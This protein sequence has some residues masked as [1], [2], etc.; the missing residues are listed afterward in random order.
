MKLRRLGA[1]GIIALFAAAA[2]TPGATPGTS[3]GT[4]PG[5][6][7]G[8]TPGTTPDTTPGTTPGALGEIVIGAGEPILIGTALAITGD[9]ATLGLD[10]Q[11]GAEI[12]GD[13][14]NEAGGLLGHDIAWA[15]EDAGCA[16]A[17]TGQ[18][19][20]QSLV[21]NDN[22]VAVIGT[23]CSRTAVPAAPVLAQ[24]G[25]ILIS[26]ANTSPTLTDPTHAEFA[27]DFYLRSAHNDL[28][29]G[30]AVA[31]YACE[32]D[33]T[34]AA[35]VHDGSTYSDNLRQAFERAFE[36]QCA[37]EIVSQ[38]ATT[39]DEVNFAGILGPIADAAP[40][41]IFLP[42]FHPAGTSII[43][44]ARDIT[45]LNDTQLVGTDGMLGS[46]DVLEQAGAAADGMLFSGPACAGDEYENNFLPR[47][48]EKSNEPTPIAPFHC[49]AFD[50]ANMIFAA[51]ESV[52]QQD[53]DGSL[54][55]DR[56]ALRD[57]IFAT[58]DF[59]G[60][61]GSLTCDENGDCAD[62]NITISRIE[63]AQYVVF[64]P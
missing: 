5:T 56:Q 52:A 35:T 39:A 2:C 14:K 9:V 38:Q 44:Q 33:W 51:I 23:S 25:I 54:R 24:R 55:I 18:T 42:M 17:E 40:D 48:V 59:E 8:D 45:A 1:L 32:Q 41:M 61:T 47:Y 29:Q 26:P 3:P 62:P 63:N 6:T 43:Q 27:G 12:A 49:H 50:A 30:A 16:A 20:A 60:L 58:S 28:V 22:L 53:A 21:T 37:G 11:W 13:L 64:W 34:T 31:T 15:H 10:S 4:S 46:P 36:E 19:A 7:P 57:A